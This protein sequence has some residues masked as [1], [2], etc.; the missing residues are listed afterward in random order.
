MDSQTTPKRNTEAARRA[1]LKTF[2]R[3]RAARAK[4]ELES[5]GWTVIPPQQE[6]EG[7]ADDDTR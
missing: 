1:S 7:R 6:R 5:Q 4:A 2:A 3:R